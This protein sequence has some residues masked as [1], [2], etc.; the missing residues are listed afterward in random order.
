KPSRLN[1][2]QAIR[3]EA[4]WK[5]LLLT[6]TV[7]ACLSAVSCC[8][9]SVTRQPLMDHY[10]R[11][12]VLL[13]R[14]ETLPTMAT[15]TYRLAYSS[16][17]FSARVKPEA[18]TELIEVPVA[19]VYQHLQ[20][21]R[22]AL[23]LVWWK[24]NSY[25][26]IRRPRHPARQRT[27]ESVSA[28]LY[29]ERVNTHSAT[30]AF[31]Y[32][33]CGCRDTTF[34]LCGLE[35]CPWYLS[36]WIYFLATLTLLSW[37]MRILIQYKIAYVHC[38]V[39]KF[40]PLPARVVRDNDGNQ[41]GSDVIGSSWRD[42]N[43]LLSLSD[44]DAV[45]AAD[46]SQQ[47]SNLLNLPS[48]SEAVLLP[49]PEDCDPLYY[50]RYET[51]QSN[52]QRPDQNGRCY[53]PEEMA[54]SEESLPTY[55]LAELACRRVVWAQAILSHSRSWFRSGANSAGQTLQQQQQ[56]WRGSA[57][58]S[59]R[60]SQHSTIVNQS[61]SQQQQQQQQH[62]RRNQNRQFVSQSRLPRSVSDYHQARPL[63]AILRGDGSVT[64]LQTVGS[65]DREIQ[66]AEVTGDSFEALITWNERS[67]SAWLLGL[68]SV[69]CQQANPGSLG[70]LASQPLDYQFVYAALASQ[71]VA[72]Q[73]QAPQ[74]QSQV[75]FAVVSVGQTRFGL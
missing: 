39:Q 11:P 40:A 17:D 10:R 24:I 22:T 41:C 45:T 9:L 2:C 54:S 66:T 38:H 43:S 73:L 1:L 8:Q 55:A 52:H 29:Y 63:M 48:Y 36:P 51:V 27:G 12:T 31:N 15:C 57:G 25:H 58:L 53:C 71:L 72:L 16:H 23:P 67:D 18:P 35:F 6:L 7:A 5:C 65:D 50:M 32:A 75:L 61:R 13:C 19:S 70:Q 64:A 59:R 3:R 68:A 56:N 74:S 14:I 46:S 37:P 21:V 34:Q 62:R 69:C 28:H 30:G 42:S 33:V 60:P 26:Y 49:L 44:P 20:K 4:H 47:A